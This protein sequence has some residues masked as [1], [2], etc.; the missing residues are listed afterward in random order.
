MAFACLLQ[1]F[2]RVRKLM[3]VHLLQDE[4]MSDDAP[5]KGTTDEDG[6]NYLSTGKHFGR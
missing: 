4:Y 1:G 3:E 2:N 6:E 5:N